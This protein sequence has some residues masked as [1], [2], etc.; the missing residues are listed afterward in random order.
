MKDFGDGEP[1]KENSLR[2]VP[3]MKRDEDQKQLF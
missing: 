1:Q 2:T 3:I